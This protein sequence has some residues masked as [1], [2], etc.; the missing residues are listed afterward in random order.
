[1]HTNGPFISVVVPA[2]N[3]EQEI[4]S[5]LKTLEAQSYRDVEIIVV[6]NGSTDR[7]GAMARG[8]NVRVLVEPRQGIAQ[9]R[10][11]GRSSPQ[12]TRTA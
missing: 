5:C 8:H 12:P 2:W 11:A 10:Q 1:M 9:A 7:T 3:E 6:D 4:A